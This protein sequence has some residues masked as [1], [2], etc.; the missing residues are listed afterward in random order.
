[1]IEKLLLDYTGYVLGKR[2][3]NSGTQ[4]INELYKERSVNNLNDG[5]CALLSS[6]NDRN[7]KN[8]IPDAAA[9]SNNVYF[10]YSNQQNC[11]QTQSGWNDSNGWYILRR[12]KQHPRI[13]QEFFNQIK[14]VFNDVQSGFNSMIF[15]Q[16]TSKN[17]DKNYR[18]AY[19]TQGTDFKEWR[20]WQANLGQG[21]HFNP[22][23]PY[24][25]KITR[26]LQN[27]QYPLSLKNAQNID[28]AVKKF[29]GIVEL[30]F[31]GHS[32]GGGLATQNAVATGRPAITFN[33][34]SLSPE[35]L[36]SYA[37][38][39]RKLMSS[40]KLVSIYMAG[41]VLSTPISTLLGLSKPGIRYKISNREG[42]DFVV[43]HLMDQI[44]RFYRL[45]K[46]I[47]TEY[48]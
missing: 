45:R 46:R 7:N 32:L 2:L 36:A 27:K 40:E 20:D 48:Y 11:Y 44:C 15:Y 10:L 25:N 3:N 1:M 33:A 22:H 24:F 39:Y 4:L 31:M 34:A 35:T 12:D 41:E 23:N 29:Q 30:Y 17:S 21:A 37:L 38:N 5:N 6:A 47:F 14:V 9:L 26:L 19:V 13:I 18:I 28:S 16:T 8:I 43:R 42:G